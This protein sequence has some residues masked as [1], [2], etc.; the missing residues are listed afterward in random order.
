MLIENGIKVHW[1]LN[2]LLANYVD[3]DNQINKVFK[4]YCQ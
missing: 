2:G 3:H 4:K 1:F